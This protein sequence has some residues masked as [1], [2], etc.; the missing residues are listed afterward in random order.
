MLKTHRD[1]VEKS[2]FGHWT[3]TG[4]KI[5]GKILENREISPKIGKLAHFDPLLL[6]K[7]NFLGKTESGDLLS[8]TRGAK[9]VLMRKFRRYTQEAPENIHISL[10]SLH[11]AV[12]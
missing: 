2:I 12:L 6:E 1:T 7:I 5:W 9:Y 4:V 11:F 3:S 8:I 10:I